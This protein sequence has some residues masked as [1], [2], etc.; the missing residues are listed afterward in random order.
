M[1][2][3]DTYIT[4]A[5]EFDATLSDVPNDIAHL[6]AALLAIIDITTISDGSE[7]NVGTEAATRLLKHMDLLYRQ[8]KQHYSY[9]SWRNKM[10][11]LINNFTIEFFGDLTD[12]VNGLSWIDGCVPIYWAALSELDG[13]ID[14]SNWVVCS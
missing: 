2:W 5:V 12:F 10:V 9:D 8:A 7:L 13:N 11:S 6:R 3:Q 4:L 14:T 1:T